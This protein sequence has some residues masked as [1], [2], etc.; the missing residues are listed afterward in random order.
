MPKGARPRALH[1]LPRTMGTNKMTIFERLANYRKR[2][3]AVLHELPKTLKT[4]RM[5]VLVKRRKQYVERGGGRGRGR[6]REIGEREE[7]ERGE[8][9][10]DPG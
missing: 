6:E 3:A 4:N 9:K 7:R 1:E 8:R 10:D 5:T 2:S